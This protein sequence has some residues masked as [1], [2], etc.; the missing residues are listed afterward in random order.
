MHKILI[1]GIAVLVGM[2]FSGMLRGLP[3]LSMLPKY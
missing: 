3:G 2:V 1:L